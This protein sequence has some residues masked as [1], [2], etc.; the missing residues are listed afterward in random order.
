[1]SGQER[2]D[3]V[4]V[5][6]GEV[7]LLLGEL[8]RGR[9]DA[10]GKLLPLVYQELRRV[11]GRYMRD[12][13]RG[14]TLQ[15]TALVHEVFLRLVDQDHADWQ[16]RVQFFAVAAQMMRRLLVDHARRRTAAKRGVAV[17]LDLGLF[18]RCAGGENTEEI[19]AVDEILTRLETLDARQARIA[20]LRFF[21][22]F[23]VEETAEA[24]AIS[25]RTVKADWAMAKAWLRTQL[26]GRAGA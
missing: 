26:A 17:T 13:R 1:M 12:E 2:I 7:S 11:A 20:E 4:A 15:P 3:S 8:R 18:D 23:S 10:L 19:L 6:G 21:V 14:H 16:N 22:G 9:K 5:S 24:M 25:P